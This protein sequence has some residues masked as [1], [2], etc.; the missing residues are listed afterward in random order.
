M[1]QSHPQTRLADYRLATRENCLQNNRK[2]KQQHTEF[3]FFF[4]V[5]FFFF[6]NPANV[7]G[8]SHGVRKVAAA[9][10]VAAGTGTPKPPAAAE[11]WRDEI[12]WNLLL[13]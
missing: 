9:A 1:L 13:G 2:L 3:F 10:A 7:D 6:F 8:D 12:G 4:L 11:L 5:F